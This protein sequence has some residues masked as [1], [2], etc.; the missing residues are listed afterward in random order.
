MRHF[1]THTC[2][3][4]KHTQ[5]HPKKQYTHTYTS[6]LTHKLKYTQTHKHYADSETKISLN[7]VPEFPSAT[8]P[9]PPLSSF[10]DLVF[11][12]SNTVV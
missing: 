11:V 3:Q 9:R 7:L 5:H 4:H 8:P 10:L 12:F 2:K 1:H 6:T